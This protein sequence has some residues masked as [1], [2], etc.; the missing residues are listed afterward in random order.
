M[1]YVRLPRRFRNFF[2]GANDGPSLFA[3]RFVRTRE[4]VHTYSSWLDDST[5]VLSHEFSDE[6]VD[7]V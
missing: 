7:V 2:R 4:L 1:S 3:G 6:D 5:A